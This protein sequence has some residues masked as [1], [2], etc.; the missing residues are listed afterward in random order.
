MD[1]DTGYLIIVG[2]V[3]V[4]GAVL[5]TVT[6]RRSTRQ[7][8]LREQRDVGALQA[9]RQ[10]VN[11]VRIL[12]WN[13]VHG[14]HKDMSPKQEQDLMRHEV[15]QCAAVYWENQADLRS[16][17]VRRSVERLFGMRVKSALKGITSDDKRTVQQRAETLLKQVDKSLALIRRHIAD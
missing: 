2:A 6:Y 5:S 11:S 16:W 17:R 10:G 13:I 8:K 9:V 12:L 3:A 1:V 14:Y 7:G 4:Y 15:N